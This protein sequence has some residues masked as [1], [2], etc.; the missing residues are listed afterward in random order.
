M[1]S[2]ISNATL[3]VTL[4][5][6]I[7]LNGSDHGSVSHV[8]ISGINE[9]SKRIL[10]CATTPGTQIYAGS[11]AA[12][13]GVFVTDNVRYIRITNL[14]NENYVVL[15]FTDESAHYAQLTLS[16]SQVFF[17]TDVS[18]SFDNASAVADFTAV[19]IT[20]IDAM[21]NTAAVDIE[22]MVASV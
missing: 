16:P 7:V 17:I 9:I 3:K 12:A 20:R 14:D 15:H 11:T 4:T 22:I 2:K 10:T 5:E 6:K 13:N 18:S 21:A 8:A 19:N 1:A